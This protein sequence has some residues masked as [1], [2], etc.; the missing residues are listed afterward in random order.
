MLAVP[1]ATIRIPETFANTRAFP[2][3][4]LLSQIRKNIRQIQ[5]DAACGTPCFNHLA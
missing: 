5:D 4:G 1:E 3:S 2:V